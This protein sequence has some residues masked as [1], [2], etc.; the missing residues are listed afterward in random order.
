MNYQKLLIDNLALIDQLARMTGR[1]Q[2]LSVDEQQDFCGYV[3][4]KLIEDDYAVLRKFKHRSS[5][6]TYL[7]M[8]IE[9]AALD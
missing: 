1:R 3:R 2:H 7:A 5:L 8:V 9:R 6:W 4:L